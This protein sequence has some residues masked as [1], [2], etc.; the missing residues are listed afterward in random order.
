VI[1]ILL[2]LSHWA[3]K[4]RFLIE[5]LSELKSEIK[6]KKDF[7]SSLL[8]LESAPPSAACFLPDNIGKATVRSTQRLEQTGGE[9][10]FPYTTQLSLC[11]P[12]NR[13]GF[14]RELA[15]ACHA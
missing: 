1:L 4:L 13:H 11:S 5:R 7:C 8:V 12:E 10:R 14:G 15:P 6:N 9:R 2:T 3:N